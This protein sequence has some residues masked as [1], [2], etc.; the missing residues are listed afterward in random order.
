MIWRHEVGNVGPTVRSLISKY[1]Q[2]GPAAQRLACGSDGSVLQ[3][4]AIAAPFVVDARGPGA[5][6]AK[7]AAASRS[8]ALIAIVI[9]F[10]ISRFPCWLHGGDL[11]V[12]EQ[13]VR[14]VTRRPYPFAPMR[15]TGA[16]QLSHPSHI[17]I[18]NP[19]SR[20]ALTGGNLSPADGLPS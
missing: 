12:F 19:A 20:C 5:L 11:R 4:A 8:A 16:S 3:T 15:A 18:S 13:M 17:G 7:A 10:D 1:W 14:M 9:L 2:C 6:A